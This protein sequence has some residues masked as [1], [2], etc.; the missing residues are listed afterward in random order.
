MDRI[1]SLK[2]V[3]GGPFIRWRIMFIVSAYQRFC[4]GALKF[5]TDRA[6]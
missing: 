5:F 2:Q 3:S 1:I 6:Y 4:A